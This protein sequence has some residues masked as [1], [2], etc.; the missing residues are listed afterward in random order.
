MRG[1]FFLC[2]FFLGWLLALP[3]FGA[4]AGVLKEPAPGTAV[5]MPYLI[6]PVVSDERLLGYAYVSSTII[7]ASPS[8]AIDVRDRTPFIQDTYVRDVN[9]EPLTSAD[10]PSAADADALAARL[11]ADAKREV[12]ASKVIGVRIIQIQMSAR[13]PNS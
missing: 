1:L 5:E 8:A 6:T 13:N 4:G 7:A 11:L 2:L 9:A 3:A 10:E 12:G